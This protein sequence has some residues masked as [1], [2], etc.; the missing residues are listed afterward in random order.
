M[1]SYSIHYWSLVYLGIFQGIF[2]LIFQVDV[3]AYEIET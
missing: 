2:H 3:H 1:Q